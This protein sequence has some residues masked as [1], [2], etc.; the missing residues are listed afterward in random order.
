LH[1]AEERRQDE[2]QYSHPERIP[3][4]SISPIPPPLIDSP[5]MRGIKPLLQYHQPVSPK[6]ETI[7]I[8]IYIT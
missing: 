5:G 2:D 1:Q 6:Q 8:A 7:Y 3:L 4:D